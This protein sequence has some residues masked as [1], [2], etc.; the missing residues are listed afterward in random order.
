[1]ATALVFGLFLLEVLAMLCC[2]RS[3]ASRKARAVADEVQ[4]GAPR[5]SV[6][7]SSHMPL[8]EPESCIAF[9]TC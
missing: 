8:A 3:C 9:S 6:V 2:W 1:M 7:S 5:R 4:Q